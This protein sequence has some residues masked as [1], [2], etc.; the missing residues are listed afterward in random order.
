MDNVIL[1]VFNYAHNARE[2]YL[3]VK[4]FETALREEITSKVDKISDVVTGNPLVIRLVVQ[5]TRGNSNILH[6]L[7][8]PLVEEIM[9]REDLALHTS[10]VDVY[11]AWINKMESET[12]EAT[13]VSIAN[14]YNTLYSNYFCTFP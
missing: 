11:K 9:T 7:L 12:G 8:S 13:Y 2:Q 4:L 1:T 5:F 3:L 6:D 10:P 14:T